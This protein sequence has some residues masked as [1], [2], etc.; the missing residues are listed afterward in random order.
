[1]PPPA[2]L[3]VVMPPVQGTVQ[4]LDRLDGAD[5]SGGSDIGAGLYGQEAAP[6][7]LAVWPHRD[8]AEMALMRAA[9]ERG[10]PCSASAAACS[11]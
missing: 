5:F 3:P 6:E 9:L 1:M 8:R 7:T 11:C 10:V 2:A 4:L